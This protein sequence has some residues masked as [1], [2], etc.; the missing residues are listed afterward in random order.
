MAKLRKFIAYRGL[1]RPYTRISKYKKKSFIKTKTN[2][3]VV[4]FKTGN[5]HK[6]FPYSLHLIAKDSLQIRDNALE[7]GRQSANKILETTLG[8][9]GYFMQLRV[10]PFHILRENP[11][12]AGAGAD[13]FST[14]MQKS[15][16]KPIGSAVR[17]KTGQK[18]VTVS[19]NKQ[20]LALAKKALDRFR[21]KVPGSYLVELEENKAITSN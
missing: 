14:G 11:L 13:R 2:V 4:K 9:M 3:K 6:T 18:I 8:L 15:F 12:A 10:Y 20:H 17:I 21:K 1:E 19:V 7:S 5:P 16:G